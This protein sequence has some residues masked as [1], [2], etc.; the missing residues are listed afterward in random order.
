ML[1]D[2]VTI[3]DVFVVKVRVQAAAGTRVVFPPPPDTASPV[4]AHDP[5]RLDT[6]QSPAG[7]LDL[8][9]TYRVAAWDVGTLPLGLGD[10]LV[11]AP[12]DERRVALGAY[13]VFVESVLPADTTLRVPKP[14]RDPL[15]DAP[16]LWIRW[17]PWIVAALV[18]LALAA[19]RLYRWWSARRDR[20]VDDDPHARARA[21]FER[22]ERMRL[23]EAG[24]GGR[25][26]ALS[27]DVVRDYLAVRVPD[28]SASLTSTEVDRVVRDRDDVPHE[29]LGTFLGFADLVKFA[30]RR[31]TA[32]SARQAFAE[33]RAIVDATESGITARLAHEAAT[34]AA[35]TRAAESEARRYEDERRRAS[36][37]RDAA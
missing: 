32:E 17:W 21:E 27:S 28:A 26:V 5:I 31:V 10:V 30:A 6:I 7:A 15:P 8:V 1:P 37:R 35:R 13:S 18:A 14:P 25:L 34:A 2:T 19:W 16:S 3:G 4:Q 9:A 11:G 20:R 23:V 12:G 29:Q 36:T 22:L 24:E 33:A